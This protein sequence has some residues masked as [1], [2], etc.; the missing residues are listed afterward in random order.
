MK[1]AQKGVVYL[2]ALFAVTVAGVVLAATGQVWLVASQRE[3]E[4]E[5]LFIGEQFRKAIMAY[6]SNP[7]TG[8]QQYPEKLEDLLEDKRGPVPIRHLRKIYIDPMTLTDEWGVIIEEPQQQGASGSQANPRSAAGGTGSNTGSNANP[9]AMTKGIAGVYSLSMRVPRKKGNFPNDYA[10]FSEAE[11]YQDW[12]FVFRQQ[13][14]TANRQNQQNQQGRPGD[15]GASPSTS[16]F[17]APGAA[18]SGP[19][20]FGGQGGASPGQ[21]PVTGQNPF[22]R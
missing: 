18:R 12:K 3:K 5:L 16:P 9:V 2:W 19:G 20:G 17:G 22:A 11:T 4:Q 21:P 14:S 8:I 13:A 15:P 1:H 7:V 10:A 6:Y